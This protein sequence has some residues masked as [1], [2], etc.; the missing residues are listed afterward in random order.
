MFTD[1]VRSVVA[2]DPEVSTLVLAAEPITDIDTTAVDDLVELDD[3]LAGAG[4]KFIIAEMKGPVKDR[5]D[6][7]GL[8][9]RFGS[10][11]FAPTVGATLDSVLGHERDDIGN[12]SDRG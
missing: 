7:C 9:H 6:R 3:Y 11:R 4:I 2:A 5:L 8:H 10:E 1:Y 12:L